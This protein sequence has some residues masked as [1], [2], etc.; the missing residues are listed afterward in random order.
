[1]F[2]SSYH[3]PRS[4]SVSNT[5]L[6]PPKQSI[7][8]SGFTFKKIDPS[9]SV[10]RSGNA[11]GISDADFPSP[12]QQLQ[13]HHFLIPAS[14]SSSSSSP[15]FPV[16]QQ[17]QQQQHLLA[18]P[19]LVKPASRVFS[20]DAAVETDAT[21][22]SS[23]SAAAAASS[24][25]SIS[26]QPNHDL[27]ALQHLLLVSGGVGGRG[28]INSNLRHPLLVKNHVEF[29]PVALTAL[30]RHSALEQLDRR[31]QRLE[32][33]ENATE[34]LSLQQ[35]ASRSQSPPAAITVAVGGHSSRNRTD[36]EMKGNYNNLFKNLQGG[37]AMMIKQQQEGKQRLL[38]EQ[39]QKEQQ[40]QGQQ[41]AS[42]SSS[43]SKR[44][45]VPHR[46]LQHQQQP[47]AY[48]IPESFSTF[49]HLRDEY[50]NVRQKYREQSNSSRN[51]SVQRPVASSPEKQQQQ[52]QQFYSPS[53]VANPF[54]R[55][56]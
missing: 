49:Q 2:P 26:Q 33:A 46:L 10:D 37:S 52:Q 12:S 21:L 17:Q 3:P 34:G 47:T 15:G 29:T 25:C 11:G 40:E 5:L 8:T 7:T 45:R 55:N 48:D 24:S 20:V 41:H 1:M 35:Y 14:S 18:S 53:P 16:H 23:A 38:Q 9:Q 28:T 32:Q 4:P 50:L 43:S 30:L 36:D 42:P 19:F 44:R 39:Q 31:V 6:H 13:Q 51:N 22:L 56:K 27:A 54:T